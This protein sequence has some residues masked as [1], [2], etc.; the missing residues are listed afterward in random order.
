MIDARYF[1]APHDSR[2]GG[3]RL[4]S[5]GGVTFHDI[6]SQGVRCTR[7]YAFSQLDSLPEG[8]RPL[9]RFRGCYCEVAIDERELRLVLAYNAACP[10]H[11]LTED[12]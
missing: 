4:G 3:V 8:P 9:P 1:G 10:V 12:P 11:G 7:P 6:V 2:P 5:L